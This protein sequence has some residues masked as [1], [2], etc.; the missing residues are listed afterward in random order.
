MA[1]QNQL[2]DPANPT[3]LI[4]VH[5]RYT[6]NLPPHV[7]D[8]VH[9]RDTEQYPRGY[10]VFTPQH[11]DHQPIEFLDHHWYRLFAYKEYYLTYYKDQ[12]EHHT[13]GTG[14]WHPQDHQ[15][16]SYDPATPPLTLDI[17]EASGSGLLS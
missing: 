6:D 11:N 3:T 8:H 1:S 5:R 10:Y 9:W 7:K 14:Y 15:H 2:F 17:P 13:E 12:I 16:L 4:Q